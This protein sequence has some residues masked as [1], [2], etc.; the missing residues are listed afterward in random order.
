MKIAIAL[1]VVA[2]LLLCTGCE[3]AQSQPALAPVSAT[4]SGNIEDRVTKLE[5]IV[6]ELQEEVGLQPYWVRK[7]LVER[8]EVLEDTVLKSSTFERARLPTSLEARVECL[9]EKVLTSTS[10]FLED[11]ISKLERRISDLEQELGIQPSY[12]P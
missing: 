3:V 9:E 11:K 5:K 7:T 10:Y 12:W 8:V 1:I 2:S 4:A 6:E